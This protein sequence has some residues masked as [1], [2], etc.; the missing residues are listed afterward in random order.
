MGPDNDA[1]LGT[2]VQLPSLQES[3]AAEENEVMTKVW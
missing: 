2:H 3:V 1:F